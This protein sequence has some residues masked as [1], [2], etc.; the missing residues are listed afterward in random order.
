MRTIGANAAFGAQT[1]ST[2]G[3]ERLTFSFLKQT[4]LA[5]TLKHL[6]CTNA[7]SAQLRRQIIR[8]FSVFRHIPRILT[9]T[10][11]WDKMRKAIGLCAYTCY[12][13]HLMGPV[14]TQKHWLKS[15]KRRKQTPLQPGKQLFW[16]C[17][18][19]LLASC[20]AETQPKFLLQAK[21]KTIEPTRPKETRVINSAWADHT[22]AQHSPSFYLH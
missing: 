14:S 16:I 6:L 18:S 1:S 21:I 10:S 8:S 22:A 2:S 15:F 12:P 5:L 3:T 17:V 13:V 9:L 11:E 19:E 7:P 4:A 20:E